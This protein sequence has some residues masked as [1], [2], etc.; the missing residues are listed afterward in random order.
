[1]FSLAA[2]FHKVRWLGVQGCNIIVTPVPEG[3]VVCSYLGELVSDHDM[4]LRESVEAQH[5]HTVELEA[6]Y[7]TCWKHLKLRGRYSMIDAE[8]FGNSGRFL[9]HGCGTSANLTRCIVEQHSQSALLCF[10]ASRDILAGEELRWDYFS[11]KEGKDKKKFMWWGACCC[12]ECASERS[13]E[14]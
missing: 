2:I 5:D 4:R 1:V 10:V 13:G 11:G 12:P 14:K 6:D 7:Y 3:A 9:N 8:S